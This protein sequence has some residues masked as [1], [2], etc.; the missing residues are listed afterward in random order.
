[1]RGLVRVGGA[2]PAIVRYRKVVI[3]SVQAIYMP[4]DDCTDPAPATTLAR[5]D[6]TPTLSGPSR[7]GASIWLS[8]PRASSS[9][10]VHCSSTCRNGEAL[11]R[12]DVDQRCRTLAGGI[13]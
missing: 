13:S 6:R 2:A 3:T 11:R 8:T 1:L 4:A 7:T 5:L 10:I 12:G 9:R